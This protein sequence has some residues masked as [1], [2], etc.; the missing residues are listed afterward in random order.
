MPYL[1]FPGHKSFPYLAIHL[2]YLGA[3]KAMHEYECI[4]SLTSDLQGP[5]ICNYSLPP[6]D[7]LHVLAKPSILLTSVINFRPSE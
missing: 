7:M 1:L 3:H 2:H 6:L 4:L 5:G